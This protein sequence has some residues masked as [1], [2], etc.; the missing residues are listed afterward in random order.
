MVAI[1]FSG[2]FSLSNA[3]I[4]LRAACGI[5]FGIALSP[6]SQHPPLFILLDSQLSPFVSTL[7]IFATTL[8]I[9]LSAFIT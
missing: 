2:T 1:S 3:L 7:P 8:A 6:L 5:R 9:R 4:W